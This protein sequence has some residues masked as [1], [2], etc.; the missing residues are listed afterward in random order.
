MHDSHCMTPMGGV[1][2][3]CGGWDEGGGG[4]GT[5]CVNK[6]GYFIQKYLSYRMM[7]KVRGL[8]RIATDLLYD[9]NYRRTMQHF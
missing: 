8:H 9:T 3:G 6:D 4:T 5:G 1:M 7:M 2:V